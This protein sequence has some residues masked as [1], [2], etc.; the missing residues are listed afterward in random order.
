MAAKVKWFGLLKDVTAE[1][2]GLEAAAF[3][4]GAHCPDEEWS[5][6]LVGFRES[7]APVPESTVEK[8]CFGGEK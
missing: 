5:E 4:L 3:F 6:A 2:A 1:L 8:P 7:V